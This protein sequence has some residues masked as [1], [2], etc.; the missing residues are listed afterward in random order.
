MEKAQE[1][2]LETV[3]NTPML[4]FDGIFA[5]CEYANPSGSIKA[6]MISFFVERAENEGLIKPG[7]TLVEATSGNTGNA[8][9]MVAAAKGYKA[10]VLMPKGYSSERVAICRA[11][12]AEVRFVGH[13]QLQE[14]VAEAKRLNEQEGYWCPMQFEN[15]WN[16]E[17][18]FSW[19]GQEVVDQLPEDVTIDAIVQGVGTG[20]TLIGVGRALREKHNADIKLFAIE[21]AESKTL[22]KGEVGQHM[23]EGIADGFVPPILERNMDQVTE[24]VPVKSSDAVEMMKRLAKEKG[25]LA[26][27]SS[28]AN[29][30]VAQQL[31]EKYPDINNVLTFFCDAGEKY[32]MQ[33]YGGGD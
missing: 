23:I 25:I 30:L 7:D 20:G 31:I 19:L 33:Y 9:A 8:L 12:G 4:R 11:Y 16:T 21:P 10:L 2:I 24:I 6:R 27:V 15:P 14:A 5:K 1:N 22:D 32:L 17:A 18:N 13:F 29:F 26:G 3:G 28:G